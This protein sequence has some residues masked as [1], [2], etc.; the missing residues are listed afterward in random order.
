MHGLAVSNYNHS[1][2]L[3]W[4]EGILRS[5]LRECFELL[6]PLGLLLAVVAFVFIGVKG[7]PSLMIS[8]FL[9]LSLGSAFL[10]YLS[11]RPGWTEL[12]ITTGIATA[13]WAVYVVLLYPHQPYSWSGFFTFLGLI[14]VMSLG[15]RIIL[16]TRR[17]ESMPA[18]WAAAFFFQ[19]GLCAVFSL[20]FGVIAT[21][22][23][24]D[25]NLYTFDVSLGITPYFVLG[26]LIA[27]RP[28]LHS[29]TLL[30]Y[31][32]WLPALAAVQA[33][34]F[35]KRGRI[36]I[37]PVA[38]SALAIGYI[39]YFVLP[40]SGPIY[41]FADSFPRL[42]PPLP[43][44]LEPMHLPVAFRNALPSL[45][46]ALA[47]LVCWHAQEFRR[48]IRLL[49]DVFLL[50]TIFATLALGEHYFVDLVVAVPFTLAIQA[51]WTTEIPFSS[52][53]RRLATV[54][55]VVLTTGWLV[56]LRYGVRTMLVSPVLPW[57]LVLST[58][59]LSAVLAARLRTASRASSSKPVRAPVQPTA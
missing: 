28:V 56:L 29:L 44:Q 51:A 27:G 14:S 17:R 12:G 38:G 53:V 54:T 55:G 31:E 57:T 11:S 25:W 40:A 5:F 18:F 48:T 20:Q 49:A 46:L 7:V 36:N 4:T 33:A 3:K 10:I 24:W 47:I 22:Y 30:I 34:Q 9:P 43:S 1:S 8:G 32:L 35:W 39:L 13:Y 42:A 19:G 23:T 50:L 37:L 2:R 45:H 41:A 16:G 21:P 59:L 26:R 6:T 15:V 58:L 52:S